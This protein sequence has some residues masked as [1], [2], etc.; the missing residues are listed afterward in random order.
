VAVNEAGLDL[1]HRDS[2]CEVPGR[3]RDELDVRAASRLHGGGTPAQVLLC[4]DGS[5][6]SVV[7]KVLRAG[8]WSVDGHDLG[9]FMGKPQQ[10]AAVHRDLPGLSPH[11]V[12]LIGA[13]QGPGWGAYAMPW[14]DGDPPVALLTRDGAA[15]GEFGMTVRR[16]FEVLGEHG[17]A[18][19]RSPAPAGHGQAAYPGRVRRRL[20][21]LAKHLDAALAGAGTLRVNGRTIAPIGEL[22]AR[23]EG[24]GVRPA[25][26]PAALWYPVHGD[27]NLGNL[28]VRAG[29]SGQGPGF[30]V[31][32]PRGI[33]SH[34]DPVYDAAKALFSLTL[35]DAAMAGGF[36][37]RQEPGREYTVR[38]SEPV[39]ALASAA[40]GL[41]GLVASTGFFRALDR[42]DPLWRRRL[43]YAHAFHVLAESAC[44]LSDLTYRALP[45]GVS[46]WAARRE[47]AAGLY[48]CGLLLLDSLLSGPPD[49]ENHLHAHLACIAE[50]TQP[51]GEAATRG[52]HSPRT[53]ARHRR[54]PRAGARPL[55]GAGA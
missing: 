36:A 1:G 39:P 52:H 4:E 31:L 43:L 14:V 53:A 54:P 18:A 3:V 17:Y 21:L 27:L 15:G 5:G 2:L 29:Q 37:I 13:W 28:L 8:A 12:P 26:Q 10:I 38:L 51:A 49:P 41:P 46:G 42:T 16:V 19:S 47:L 24:P 23:A 35:F 9:S 45:G 33:T 20:P 44:R 32:D 34:F 30:T 25:L 11:Y 6:G 48:L 50:V 55:S 7:V 22:L 40:T